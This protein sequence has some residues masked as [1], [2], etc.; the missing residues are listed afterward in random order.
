MT[1]FILR[2]ILAYSGQIAI[3]IGIAAILTAALKLT[4]AARLR[5]LQL[6]LACVVALP[7][8]QPWRAPVQKELVTV[9]SGPGIAVAGDR[10]AREIPG[11]RRCPTSCSA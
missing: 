8:A 2:D 1:A 11:L 7:L 5:C 9:Y 10:G 4:P 6:V 3:L